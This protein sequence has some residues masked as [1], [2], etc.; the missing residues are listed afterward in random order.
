MTTGQNLWNQVCLANP[1]CV[2]NNVN[3]FLWRFKMSFTGAWQISFWPEFKKLDPRIRVWVRV[4]FFC[5]T[6][7]EPLQPKQRD[8]RELDRGGWGSLSVDA[9][10]HF[11]PSNSVASSALDSFWVQFFFFFFFK[12]CTHHF[13]FLGGGISLI[14][15]KQNN[16]KGRLGKKRTT[17]NLIIPTYL[18]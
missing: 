2:H 11:L 15:K 12:S 1:G 6:S 14:V 17:N 13:P 3:V 9:A 8:T 10:T 4:Y 5:I 18:F 16:I 7:A